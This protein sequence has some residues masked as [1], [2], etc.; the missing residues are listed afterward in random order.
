MSGSSDKV[1]G[2][3]VSAKPSSGEPLGS[4]LLR[5]P[6]S[7][8]AFSA[9]ISSVFSL[10]DSHSLVNMN[11]SPS[12]V[13]ALAHAQKGVRLIQEILPIDVR[14]TA[15]ASVVGALLT[16]SLQHCDSILLLH[17]TGVNDASAEALMRPMIESVLRLTW[18]A[19]NEQRALQVTTKTARF[20]KLSVLLRRLDPSSKKAHT[21]LPTLHGLTHAGME[22]LI[23]Y[24]SG[25]ETNK[26]P[27]HAAVPQLTAFLIV[28]MAFLAG[29][30]F[31]KFTKRTEEIKRIGQVFEIYGLGLLTGALKT[32]ITLL[33]KPGVPGPTE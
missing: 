13:E 31:C 10:P 29:A 26:P 18:V 27:E 2:C 24:V 6:E 7:I 28:V 4:G 33:P 17:Q 19:E 20:P 12:D 21:V 3:T 5:F 32:L 25:W 1:A 9:S 14:D 15:P 22:Q 11:H 16:V 30:T 23:Q 8:E